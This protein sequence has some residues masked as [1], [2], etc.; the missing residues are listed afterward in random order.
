MLINPLS[1]FQ[2]NT[3]VVNGSASDSAEASVTSFKKKMTQSIYLNI[4]EQGKA[5]A[6]EAEKNK[7]IDESDLPEEIKN[8]LK[9]IREIKAQIAEKKAEL[10]QAMQNNTL[11][12]DERAAKV[13]QLQG[14]LSSLQGALRGAQQSFNQLLQDERL[15]DGQRVTATA[16]AIK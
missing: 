6:R 12:D 1:S 10:Q 15:T 9:W 7:D 16:L 2:L 13:Q 3:P 14:E 4:S 11:S 8:L 5:K